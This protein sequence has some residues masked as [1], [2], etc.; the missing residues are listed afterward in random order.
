[1]NLNAE[2][3][4]ASTKTKLLNSTEM[5]DTKTTYKS[6]P[7]FCT[8]LMNNPKMKLRKQFG[9]G[10]MAQWLRALTALPEV[11][12]SILGNHIVAHNLKGSDVLF[13]CI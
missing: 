11:L 1:M 5:K 12:S 3:P 4:Y 7:Y 6:Q 9:A 13:W 8:L 2:N 10:E